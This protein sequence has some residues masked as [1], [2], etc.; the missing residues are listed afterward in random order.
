[1]S[2]LALE[3]MLCFSARGEAGAAEDEYGGL[4]RSPA[5]QDL[6]KAKCKA[7]SRCIFHIPP[8]TRGKYIVFD[9]W[10]GYCK[11]LAKGSG[12]LAMLH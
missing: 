7:L 5:L 2:V 3:A 10:F 6:G 8:M 4:H 9:P 11:V 12:V 1:M